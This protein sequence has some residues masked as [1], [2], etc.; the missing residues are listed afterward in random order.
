MFILSLSSHPFLKEP[1]NFFM[2][3][4]SIVLNV[5]LLGVS[6]YLLY[7]LRNPTAISTR[8]PDRCQ[9]T[10]YDYSGVPFEGIVSYTTAKALADYYNKSTTS[11]LL[12]PTNDSNLIPGNDARSVWFPLERL[13]KFIWNI[14][15]ENCGKPCPHD[16]GLR[17]YF[18]RYP[19][20]AD[21]L[22]QKDYLT[23]VST[24]FAN[25]HTVFMVPT[26]Y[27]ESKKTDVDFFPGDETCSR[28]LEEWARIPVASGE[29]FKN[30]YKDIKIPFII[31]A[32][33]IPLSEP[34]DGQNHGGLIPPGTAT[35]TSF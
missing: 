31:M 22:W 24:T 7:K 1:K 12:F 18:A 5:L 3:K 32:G 27:D 33:A 34:G 15:K 10:K 9:S 13:K 29:V 16:L 35:G 19:Q 8:V 6:G 14:E 28:P 26:Y 17:V 25:R 21:T 20:Q 11:K 30:Q 4:L 23:G 2:Q